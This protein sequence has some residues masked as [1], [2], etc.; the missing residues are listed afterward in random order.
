[1]AESLQAYV[2]QLPEREDISALVE[3]LVGGDDVAE[4]PALPRTV[5]NL[6][7]LMPLTSNVPQRFVAW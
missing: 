7:L 1:M 3:F 2:R 6:P 5:S 4:K